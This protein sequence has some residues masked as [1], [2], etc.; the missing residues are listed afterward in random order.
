MELRGERARGTRGPHPPPMDPTGLH[1]YDG[2]ESG[3][4]PGGGD[5][6]RTI[7]LL[8]GFN[9]VAGVWLAVSPWV[10]GYSD[11]DPK[12]NDVVV[13][14]LIA[15]IA[16]IRISGAFEDAWL[17]LVNAALGA[18]L[19]VAAFTVDATTA[20]SWNDAITGGVVALLALGSAAS[21]QPGRTG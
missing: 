14:S 9:V 1:P 18:W 13:G 15:L 4:P 8:S 20:A 17:S 2:H 5:P 3:P 19:F 12:G 16:L 10:L 21:S 11:G 7:V 6:R